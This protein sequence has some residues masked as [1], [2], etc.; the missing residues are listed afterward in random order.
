[1]APDRRFAGGAAVNVMR[2]SAVGRNR[3][4]LGLALELL[5]PVGLDQ[6]VDHEGAPR[7]PLTVLAMAAMDEHRPRR[8]PIAHSSARAA[9]FEP[10]V[11][12]SP[13]P[14]QVMFGPNPPK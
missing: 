12:G 6:R 2:A 1:M 10:R 5:D 8:Q 14:P 11:H 13:R 3:D 7:L 9:A 4:G